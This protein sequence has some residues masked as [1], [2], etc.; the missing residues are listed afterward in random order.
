M[1]MEMFKISWQDLSITIGMKRWHNMADVWFSWRNYND[2]HV[3][4]THKL[5]KLEIHWCPCHP[6]PPCLITTKWVAGL[7]WYGLIIVNLWHLHYGMLLNQI[8]ASCH[9]CCHT[10][11]WHNRVA[12]WPIYIITINRQREKT[13][14]HRGHKTHICAADNLVWILISQIKKS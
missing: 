9:F 2:T 7:D 4:L 6:C 13:W 14:N 10:V 3:R 8:N 11:L 12:T 5:E 1:N